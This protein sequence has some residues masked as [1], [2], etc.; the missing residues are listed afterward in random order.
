MPGITAQIGQKA[1]AGE[2]IGGALDT[3]SDHYVQSERLKLENK[4]LEQV[5]QDLTL[6][7]P[8]TKVYGKTNSGVGAA[9]A[10]SVASPT[11]SGVPDTRP[12]LRPTME[13]TARIPVFNPAGDKIMVPK[14][15]ADRMG[16]NAWGYL[17]AGE[18]TE[19]VGEIRGEGETAVAM[20]DIARA[21]GA[22]FFA[23]NGPLPPSSFPPRKPDTNGVGSSSGSIRW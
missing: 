7:T 16:I 12:K 19:L 10:A 4:R 3:Y 8:G 21:T 23:D 13:T 20:G 18:Y 6:R 9:T 2:I 15:F 14:S 1:S 5:A 11:M 22:H 17:A